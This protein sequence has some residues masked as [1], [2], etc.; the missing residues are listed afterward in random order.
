MDKKNKLLVASIL[1]LLMIVSVPS[2]LAYFSTYTSAKGTKLVS[3]KNETEMIETVEGNI[4]TV[5][6]KASEDSSPVL[7]RVKAF[8]PDFVTLEPSLGQGWKAETDGFYY[9]QDAISAGQTT[10]K[11]SFKVNTVTPETTK[12][13]DE[14]HVVIIYESRL[15]ALGD[16]WSPVIE[17]GE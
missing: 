5:Q 8:S 7:V 4:K 2:V 17:G 14:F 10:S 11:I 12:P 1:V 13:G 3:M 16:N 6:I 9:Y 15:Q